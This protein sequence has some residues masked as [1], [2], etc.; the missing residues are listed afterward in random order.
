MQTL[1]VSVA[2]AH[3]YRVSKDSSKGDTQGQLATVKLL[4]RHSVTIPGGQ[5]MTVRAVAN[6]RLGQD[7]DVFIEGRKTPNLP[8][9]VKVCPGMVKLKAGSK[10][11]LQVVLENPS[12]HDVTL[13]AKSVLGKLF[14]PESVRPVSPTTIAHV[15]AATIQPDQPM[16]SPDL[17]FDFGSSPISDEW[18]SRFNRLLQDRHM[19]FSRNDLDIG[20]TSKVKHGIR[21][22]DDTPFRE[23]RRRIAPADYE[24]V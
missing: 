3:A 11:K 23:G 19:V 5:S 6:N 17:E 15:Q 7:T 20:C 22:T 1:R 4:G 21:L 10:A 12:V 24:D 18:R 8:G 13:P 2:W 16:R 9:G 14:M